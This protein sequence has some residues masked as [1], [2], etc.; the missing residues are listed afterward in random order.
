MWIFPFLQLYDDRMCPFFSQWN[1]IFMSKPLSIIRVIF[2]FS[3][4]PWNFALFHCP[5]FYVKMSMWEYLTRLNSKTLGIRTNNLIHFDIWGFLN[6]SGIT[7]FFAEWTI[8]RFLKF[9]HVLFFRKLFGWN[10]MYIVT[11]SIRIKRREQL[12][13]WSQ[14]SLIYIFS[15]KQGIE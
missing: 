9:L 14:S 10:N 6:Y 1:K 3:E 12:A 7:H 11:K 8:P 4:N 5:N 15:H 2:V 13:R